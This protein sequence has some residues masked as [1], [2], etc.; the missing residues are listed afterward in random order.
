MARVGFYGDVPG[1]PIPP[2][3]LKRWLLQIDWATAYLDETNFAHPLQGDKLI[4]KN[5]LSWTALTL[6]LVIPLL[7]VEPAAQTTNTT[8]TPIGPVF[9]W[10]PSVYPI[11]GTWYLEVTLAVADASATATVDLAVVGGAQVAGSAITTT[12]T[13]FSRK[14]S[15]ALTM[16]TGAADLVLRLS[17]NN[18]S[19][20]A[21]IKG[22]RL[23][24]FN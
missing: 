19:Y 4:A 3:Y 10:D 11:T 7:L 24:R 16:P 23:I 9:G 18:A 1:P 8:P 13:A 17:T 14:Q 5:S 6:P 20:A 12:S 2:D 21:Q 22:A 15:S